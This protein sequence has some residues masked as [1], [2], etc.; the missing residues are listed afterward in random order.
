MIEAA[1][2]L[3][4]ARSVVVLTGA[5]VSAE[6]GVPTFRDAQ[7]G[8]WARYDPETLAS[9]E[10]FEAN[11]GLVWRW[12]MSRFGGLQAVRPNPGHYALA[13]LEAWMT[14]APPAGGADADG[15]GG[16]GDASGQPRLQG[17]RR[18][19]RRPRLR[20]QER[21]RRHDWAGAAPGSGSPPRARSAGESKVLPGPA[22]LPRRE[23]PGT[24]ALFTQNVD[25]LHERA[26]SIRVQHLHG[27]IHRY[28]CHD[29]LAP[30]ELSAGEQAAPEPPRCAP[31]G[32]MIRPDVVWFGESL[33]A[34]VLAAATRAALSC[35]VMLVA[36]TSG[37]VYPAAQ[38]PFTAKQAGARVI[39]VNPEPTPIS[40][41]ADL[42]LQ[43]PGGVLLPRILEALAEA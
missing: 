5:G 11:P 23:E 32:G 33:P 10:G 38:L 1:R 17:H 34:Q 31:C 12:Y 16:A 24:F 20:R 13:A 19:R 26:G 40:A 37:Q 6:S 7:T 27:R 9:A 36:G 3:R 8:L 29:C 4:A 28:R 18:I 14:G 21:R 42:F 15:A 2:A 35:S 25:D 22:L 30:H 43:G 41:L 39:D